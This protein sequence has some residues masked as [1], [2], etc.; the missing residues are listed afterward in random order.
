MQGDSFSVVHTY[1]IV[2]LVL[3]KAGH[4]LAVWYW[5]LWSEVDGDL[6][7]GARRESGACAVCS[8]HTP[9]LQLYLHVVAWLQSIA[10]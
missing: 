2:Y 5:P 1:C 10:L 9:R 8:E 6:V 3:G 7:G 4:S